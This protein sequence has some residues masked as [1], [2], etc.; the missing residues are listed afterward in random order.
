MRG[1][2]GQNQTYIVICIQTQVDGVGTPMLCCE[3]VI[4]METARWG[5]GVVTERER[6]Q[7][8]KA[9]SKVVMDPS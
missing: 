5:K 3:T 6:D 2:K 8:R 4:T 1:S 9:H 7:E